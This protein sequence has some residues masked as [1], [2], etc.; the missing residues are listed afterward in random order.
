MNRRQARELAV[1]LIYAQSM[2]SVDA[3]SLLDSFFS[4]E[5]YSTLSSE[6]KLFESAPDEKQLNYIRALVLNCYDH[7]EEID[8][9]IASY[10]LN[11]SLERISRTAMALLRCALTEMLYLDGWDTNTAIAINEIVE[12][13]KNYEE[14]ETVGFINGVLGAVAGGG[15]K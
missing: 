2:L 6:D 11:W 1:R 10:S 3:E 5:H 14:P 9:E 15:S 7:L 8:N 13:A 4:E 12:L